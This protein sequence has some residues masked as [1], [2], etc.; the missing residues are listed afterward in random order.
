MCSSRRVEQWRQATCEHVSQR[1]ALASLAKVHE[2][3]QTYSDFKLHEICGEIPSLS[4]RQLSKEELEQQTALE[5][6]H[7]PFF[8]HFHFFYEPFVLQG[9]VRAA[10][11]P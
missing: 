3:L 1:T 9:A 4:H 5:N 7:F 2:E 8:I 10:D 11:S 6:V